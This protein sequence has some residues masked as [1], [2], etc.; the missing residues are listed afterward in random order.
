MAITYKDGRPVFVP[1]HPSDADESVTHIPKEED[2]EITRKK[3]IRAAFL[4]AVGAFSIGAGGTFLLF[5]WPKKVGSFGSKLVVG[6][7]SQFPPG[8]V[9]RDRDGRFYLVS[10]PD[11]VGNGGFMALYWKCVHLGCTVPWVPTE[12]FTYSGTLYHGTFHCPCH[13]STYVITG[14]NVAGPA[15]RP[16]DLMAVSVAGGKIT[17]DTGKITRRDRFESAQAVSG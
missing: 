3:F 8:S 9:Y 7:T 11:G 17:V 4:G 13:G 5:F 16:L 14:Q 15:P 1:S 12:D 6:P 2:E 10:L